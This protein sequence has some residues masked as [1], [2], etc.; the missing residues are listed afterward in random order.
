MNCQSHFQDS[1]ILVPFTRSFKNKDNQETGTGQRGQTLS[2]VSISPSFTCWTQDQQAR[3]PGFWGDS[4]HF[5]E[6][7]T[8]EIFPC[9]TSECGTQLRGNSSGS[10]ASEITSLFIIS[11]PLAR[12]IPQINRPLPPI[13]YHC[14]CLYLEIL[15]T[16]STGQSSF[17]APRGLPPSY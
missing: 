9:Y 5:T 2:R 11:Y 16:R 1:V 15:L 3:S 7:L 4:S 8:Y 10:D 6:H 12:D 13:K 14:L 17:L